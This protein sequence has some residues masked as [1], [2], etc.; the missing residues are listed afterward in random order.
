[1]SHL[2]ALRL[3]ELVHLAV[4]DADLDGAKE[5]MQ[6]CRFYLD[7]ISLVALA[8]PEMPTCTASTSSR[9]ADDLILVTT[10]SSSQMT[11]AAPDKAVRPR[12]AAARD[13]GGRRRRAKP[14]G[15]WRG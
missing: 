10:T 9:P 6:P 11:A 1:M 4:P 8:V 7:S 15:C 5:M 2:A 3:A 14:T 12:D 13:G